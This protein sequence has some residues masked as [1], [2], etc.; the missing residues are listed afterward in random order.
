VSQQSENVQYE[1]AEVSQQSEN[2]Q[3]ESAKHVSV[4]NTLSPDLLVLFTVSLKVPFMAPLTLPFMGQPTVLSKV[5][6]MA[7]P[8]VSVVPL[9]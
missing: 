5:P 6:S 1:S 9:P 3:Y 8:K 7:P 4:H 2:V